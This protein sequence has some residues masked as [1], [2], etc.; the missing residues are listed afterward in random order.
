MLR[1]TLPLLFVTVTACISVESGDAA[2]VADAAADAGGT[3]VPND[4]G[5]GDADAMA[6]A[7]PS[8]DSG[9]AQAG[10]AG[11]CTA[12]DWIVPQAVGEDGTGA[13]S[14]VGTS[15]A[16]VVDG[17]VATCVLSAVKPSCTSLELR[18]F[19]L[20]IPPSATIKGVELQVRRQASVVGAIVDDKVALVEGPDELGS[21]IM[22]AWSSNTEDVTYGSP[23]D[24]WGNALTHALVTSNRFRVQIRPKYAAGAGS[25]TASVDGVMLR[26]HYC[27]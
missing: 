16:R 7:S 4:G 25:I 13:V 26:V 10:D 17:N 9:D 14:W 5:L 2:G 24:T 8:T 21:K 18:S 20:V 19:S 11:T 1:R 6:E 23:S 27:Y 12:T 3:A 22:G 15:T